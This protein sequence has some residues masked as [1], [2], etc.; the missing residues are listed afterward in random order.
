VEFSRPDHADEFREQAREFFA[1]RFPDH[2]RPLRFERPHD[3]AFYKA[4][5]EFQLE[6]LTGRDTYEV[7]AFY[8][9]AAKAGIELTSYIPTKMIAQTL[10]ELG[11]VEQQRDVVPRMLGGD[12]LVALGLSEPDSGS[13]L[14]AA[15]TSAVRDGDEWRING[16]KIYTSNAQHATHIFLLTRTNTEVAKHKGLTVFLV[17]IDT[18]GVEVHPIET[19]AY[20][21][22]NMT[23]YNDVRV[24]DSARIGEVDGGWNVMKFTLGR[25]QSGEGSTDLPA[26]VRQ[27]TLWAEQTEAPDGNRMVDDPIVRE[28]LARAAIDLEVATLLARRSGWATA[29][30]IPKDPGWGPGSKLFETEAYVRAAADFFAMVGPEALIPYEEEGTVAGGWFNYCFRDAPLRTI[31]GGASEV[32]RE[33]IAER[34]LGLP[35][36]RP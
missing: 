8:E 15:R 5:S 6:H 30:D 10:E 28:R 36:A 21:P 23:F 18:P 29:N 24:P 13:D 27:A 33:I 2:L 17:P 3:P 1:T 12:Y 25:E 35:R 11:T 19:L 4:V 16:Q 34:R 26:L 20:H 14:A 7:G 32:M 22:T 31:G 9:E